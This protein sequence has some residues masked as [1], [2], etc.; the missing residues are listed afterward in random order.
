MKDRVVV[1]C[2]VEDYSPVEVR[3]ENTNGKTI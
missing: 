3:K 1:L 2:I